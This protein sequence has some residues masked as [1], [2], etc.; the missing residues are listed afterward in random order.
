MNRREWFDKTVNQGTSGDQVHDILA[1]W[2]EEN[3][4]LADRLL[5]IFIESDLNAIPQLVRE[6]R[7][8]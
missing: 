3:R 8:A 6:I 7:N 4:K 2:K 5:D 1:D